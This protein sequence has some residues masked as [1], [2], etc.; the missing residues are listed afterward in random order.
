M[1]EFADAVMAHTRE[2]F[3]C[4]IPPA[5]TAL[6]L[7]RVESLFHAQRHKGKAASLPLLAFPDE[8]TANPITTH[9]GA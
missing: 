5:A 8:F 7:L 9:T 6:I 1:N 3:M 4:D 2:G